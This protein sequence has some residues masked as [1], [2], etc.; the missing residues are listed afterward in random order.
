MYKESMRNMDDGYFLPYIHILLWYKES[1]RNMEDDGIIKI[2]QNMVQCDQILISR[3]H[4][5][6]V[7]YKM[8]GWKC[9][10]QKNKDYHTHDH[11]L[12]H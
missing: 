1:M 9:Y 2:K 11:Y 10:F 3:L 6:R 4:H 7:K 8:L 5:A 12:L